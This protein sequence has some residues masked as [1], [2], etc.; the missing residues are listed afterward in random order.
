MNQPLESLI[1]DNLIS[2]F[3]VQLP[4]G[5]LNQ[6]QLFIENIFKM[7][8]QTSYVQHYQTSLEKLGLLDPGNKSILMSYDFHVDQSGNLKLIEINTNAAFLALGEQ[9]YLAREVELPIANFKISEIKANIEEELHLQKKTCPSDLKIAII[10]EN[11]SQQRLFVEFLVYD[12][13]FKSWGWD[14][15]IIDFRELFQDFQPEFVYNR[16]TDFFLVEPGNLLLRKKFLQKEVCLSPNPYEYF[17][18]ADKQRL[19]DW[20]SPGFLEAQGLAG[21]ELNILKT[22]LPQSFDVTTENAAE[23]WGK[24]KSLFF[25]PKNSFGSKQS[26]RGESISRKA[27]QET[28]NE[29]MIAQ[30]FIPAP[31]KIFETPNGPQAFKFDLRCYAY[32]GRL[33]M[34]VARIYQG[35]VT[36]LRTP[37]GGFAPVVFQ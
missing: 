11:P 29:N 26:F 32:K 14:S 34:V 37:M 12:A 3:V 36:N 30:E 1:S 27:F 31:E 17:L 15:K 2:P 24:R 8:E 25:K 35:Q 33:Q 22:C 10:D 16:H 4:M 28:L 18:L 19:I 7:R 6:A 21:S 9:M 5:I 23:I 20:M 13:L